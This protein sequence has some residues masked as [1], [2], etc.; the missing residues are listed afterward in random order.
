MTHG[1]GSST[2]TQQYKIQY[3]LYNV[4]SMST[5]ITKLVIVLVPGKAANC[6]GARY[7]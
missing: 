5:N 4:L 6:K 7:I 3:L 1:G 2:A